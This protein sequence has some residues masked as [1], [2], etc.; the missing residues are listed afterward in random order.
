MR[1]YICVRTNAPTGRYTT[2]KHTALIRRRTTLSVGWYLRRA[3][4]SSERFT[5]LLNRAHDVASHA[6]AVLAR[7][8]R[9]HGDRLT[10]PIRVAADPAIERRGRGREHQA[11]DRLLWRRR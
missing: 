10:V 4:L 1:L 5:A 7:F 9:Y 11:T 6:V 2:L 8:V 3:V